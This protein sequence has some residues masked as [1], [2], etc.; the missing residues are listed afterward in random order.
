MNSLGSCVLKSAQWVG[1]PNSH[2]FISTS[3]TGTAPIRTPLLCMLSVFFLLVALMVVTGG[4]FG[5]LTSLKQ[6][7]DLIRKMYGT[8]DAHR[9]GVHYSPMTYPEVYQH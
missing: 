1:G 3:I 8:S 4:C 7:V 5:G 6:V 9:N 2:S